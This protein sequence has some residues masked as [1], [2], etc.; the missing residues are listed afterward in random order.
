[1]NTI[2]TPIEHPIDVLKVQS[3]EENTPQDVHNID[4]L[5]QESQ[6][7]ALATTNVSASLALAATLCLDAG[8]NASDVAI[9]LLAGS[10][11]TAEMAGA[12]ANLT[13]TSTT[14]NMYEVQYME[15]LTLSS[16]ATLTFE[17]VLEDFI[18]G[19]LQLNLGLH[20]VHLSYQ[21]LQATMEEFEN[22]QGDPEGAIFL[23]AQLFSTLQRQALWR[24]LTLC[25]R[26]HQN[27]LLLTPCVNLLWHQF[28]LHIP[29][30]ARFTEHN[31]REVL[32][33][34]WQV[35]AKDIAAYHLST[36]GI[37]DE[38]AMLHILAQ[39]E[40]TLTDPVLLVN[41]EWHESIFLLTRSFQ[42][43]LETFYSSDV[44]HE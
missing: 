13:H 42:H 9:A 44:T 32:T 1:M 41:E 40:K 14:E 27:L 16:Q 36:F 12:Y 21:R 11:A 22:N 33:D 2:N 43:T 8:S 19:L 29:S 35:R 30:Q 25:T 7:C 37:A 17:T 20:L 26:L 6:R 39:Q 3:R 10:I 34:T 28:R 24:N 38:A 15:P 18:K 4:A 5:K 31:V 23:D